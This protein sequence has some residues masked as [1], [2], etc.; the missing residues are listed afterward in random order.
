MHVC[1]FMLRFR[2]TFPL[3]VTSAAVTELVGVNMHVYSL[4]VSEREGMDC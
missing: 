3:C 2:L 4:C 1:M